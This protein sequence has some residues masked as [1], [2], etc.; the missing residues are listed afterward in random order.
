MVHVTL[1]GQ[2]PTQSV[3]WSA[4]F[5]SALARLP[6][7]SLDR[8]DEIARLIVL[9]IS[10]IALLVA[11]ARRVADHA[12]QRLGHR[13]G[14]RL[15]HLGAAVAHAPCLTVAIGAT[16]RY[17]LLAGLFLDDRGGSGVLSS[18][19]GFDLR[20][21]IGLVIAHATVNNRAGSG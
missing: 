15:A 17:Y 19:G 11:V 4:H 9:N 20:L 10:V 18:R 12:D 14:H 16:V 8:R 13:C 1:L 2:Q 6:D 7:A 5:S 21:Q 3:I